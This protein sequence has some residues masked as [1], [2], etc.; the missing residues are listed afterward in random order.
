MSSQ[1]T[2]FLHGITAEKLGTPSSIVA[3]IAQGFKANLW[4]VPMK[5]I[6]L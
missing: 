4:L 1:R 2:G 3:Q 5:Q 6:A